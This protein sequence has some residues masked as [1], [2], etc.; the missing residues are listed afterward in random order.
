MMSYRLAAERADRIAAIVPVAGAYD[1]ESFAPSRPVAV[2]HIHSVDDPRA[3][4]EGGLGPPFP[5]TEVRSSHRPVL[6]GVNRWVRFNGC[7]AEPVATESRSGRAG[8]PNAGQTA[9]LL[10][11]SGCSAGAPVAH[12]RL[13]GVGHGWPGNTDIGL[14]EEVIGPAT[15]L[16]EAAVEAWRFVAPISRA[17][18]SK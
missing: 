8:T 4:Y 17:V 15:T 14:R 6:D 16:L 10:T 12:W 18:E 9:A 13:T 2:L 11:W 1:M 5:G 7:N 3:L